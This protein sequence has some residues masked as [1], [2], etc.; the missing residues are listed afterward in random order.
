[1][2]MWEMLFLLTLK[3]LG[4]DFKPE[5]IDV[6]WTILLPP[7]K[8]LKIDLERLNILIFRWLKMKND[9]KKV[10]M[11]SRDAEQSIVPKVAN[12]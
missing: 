2:L 3:I 9:L 10:I 12:C 4:M 5:L 7:R 1:M 8:K 11:V 6:K